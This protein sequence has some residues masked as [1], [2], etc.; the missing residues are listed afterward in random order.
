[1]SAYAKLD[2]TEHGKEN[3]FVHNILSEFTDCEI[4]VCDS[5]DSSSIS[6]LDIESTTRSPSSH[7]AIDADASNASDDVDVGEGTLSRMI[8]LVTR[9]TP[10]ILSLIIGK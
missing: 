4:E 1:M 7:V 3:L 5:P 9:A 10:L 6:S 8:I 2:S